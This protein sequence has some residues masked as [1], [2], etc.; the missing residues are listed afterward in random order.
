MNKEKDRW[1]EIL[2]SVI[3]VI[4]FLSKR[5]F[6]FMVIGKILIQETREIVLKL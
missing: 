1:R 5:I 4:K 6:L 2:Q 3:A